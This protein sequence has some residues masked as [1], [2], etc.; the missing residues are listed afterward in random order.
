MSIESEAD[1]LGLRAVGAV[2]AKALDAM[3][4]HV[5]VG[6]TTLELDSVAESVLRHHGAS[7]AAP[8]FEAEFRT[9]A[10]SRAPG[11]TLRTSN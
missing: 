11:W 8:A 10:K 2:V 5:A 9:C 7:D 3:R 4:R 1:V 6:V